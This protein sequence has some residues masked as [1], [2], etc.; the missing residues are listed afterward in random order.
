M[1]NRLLK[2][3]INQLDKDGTL[4]PGPAPR[5]V[6]QWIE[7]LGMPMNV[8]RFLQW[9]W[10]RVDSWVS[11][12]NLSASKNLIEEETTP[13]PLVPYKFLKLGSA[14]NG[15]PFVIDF[16]E[17]SCVPGFVSHD[18]Y[19]EGRAKPRSAFEPIARS[20]ESLLYRLTEGLFVPHD[21]FQAKDFNQFLE[22]E[23]SFHM[24]PRIW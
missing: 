20:F 16:L 17:D 2:A 14:L 10:V 3:F 9:H 12:L 15:D 1:E 19:W 8:M 11:P 5:N 6:K 7:S 21:Y 13:F 18:L 4:N 22:R 23:R 24:T